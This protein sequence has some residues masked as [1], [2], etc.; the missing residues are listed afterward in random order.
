[1]LNKIYKS[2]G[3]AKNEKIEDDLTNAFVIILQN[4]NFNYEE[5]ITKQIL[6]IFGI[7]KGELDFKTS[8][9][10]ATYLQ[11]K[12]FNEIEQLLPS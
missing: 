11:K 8:K 5:P 6:E 12:I 9:E 10:K 2:S 4:N 7:A 3:H 1:M